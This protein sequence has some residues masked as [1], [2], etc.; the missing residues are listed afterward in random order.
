VQGGGFGG[1]FATT[2]TRMKK[3]EIGAFSWTE[4]MVLF[5][6]ATTGGLA[7][8]DFAGNI[9]NHILERFKVTFDYERRLVHLEPG[10]RFSQ[11]DH[12]TSAGVRLGKIDGRVLALEVLPGSPAAVAGMKVPDQIVAVDGKPVESYTI[13]QLSQLFEHGPDGRK[14]TIE[15]LRLKSDPGLAALSGGSK[16]PAD[17]WKKKKFR[18]ALKEML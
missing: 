15:A 5:S 4:P 18:F 10:A 17:G 7:S 3:M 11:R 12:F 2:V 8:E 14:H 13:D 9:G 1:S 16:L 6:G